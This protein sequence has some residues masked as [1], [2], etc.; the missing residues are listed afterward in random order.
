MVSRWNIFEYI[1]PGRIRY[2]VWQKREALDPH[3]GTRN[4]HQPFVGSKHRCAHQGLV[5][6]N[7]AEQDSLV[8]HRGRSSGGRRSPAANAAPRRH[9]KQDGAEQKKRGGKSQQGHGVPFPARHVFR[10]IVQRRSLRRRT[11][12]FRRRS[13]LSIRTR[14]LGV[15]AF[16]IVGPK[17]TISIP[18]ISSAMAPHSS[19][20]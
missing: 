15:C 6:Q 14:S 19:P 20:A 9:E 2:R 3:L 18:G 13:T 8:G 12:S 16:S 4:G 11:S 5:R 10:H 7:P 1:F 17:E